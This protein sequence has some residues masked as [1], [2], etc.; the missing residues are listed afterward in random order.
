MSIRLDLYVQSAADSKSLGVGHLLTCRQTITP[1]HILVCILLH[2]TLT[3]Y[4]YYIMT[5]YI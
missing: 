3:S 4:T 1:L 2:L 5:V